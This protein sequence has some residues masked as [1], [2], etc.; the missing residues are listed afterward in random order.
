MEKDYIVFSQKMAGFLM[1]NGC[2]LL[3]MKNAKYEPTK[4]VYFFPHNDFVM[5]MVEKYQVE[6]R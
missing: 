2:R 4:F 5:D 6:H 1:Y 3:K